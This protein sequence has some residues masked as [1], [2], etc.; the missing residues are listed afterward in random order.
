[1]AVE[2]FV[3]ALRVLRVAAIWIYTIKPAVQRIVI[4]GSQ[5]ILLG[6]VVPLLAG[7]EQ[8]LIDG[9]LQRVNTPA[10]SVI[11]ECITA[12]VRY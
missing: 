6:G 11:S 10:V 4:A 9:V 12:A 8:A 5:V 7:V 1:M 3:Q 2:V